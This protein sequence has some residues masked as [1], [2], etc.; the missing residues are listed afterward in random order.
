MKSKK[1]ITL[2]L[3][4]IMCLSFVSCGDKKDVVDDEEQKYSVVNQKPSANQSNK[5]DKENET[6]KKDNSNSTENLNKAPSFQKPSVN[7]SKKGSFVYSEANTELSLNIPSEWE[8]YENPL[9]EFSYII[10]LDGSNMNLITE[11]AYNYSLD[12]Y[13][14]ESLKTL[15]NFSDIN[16]LSRSKVNINGREASIVTYET[17]YQDISFKLYQVNFIVDGYAYIFTFGSPSETYE[18]HKQGFEK[19]VNSIKFHE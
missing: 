8:E 11:Y 19:A 10:S 4:S 16:D 2:T 18:I 5:D 3:L 12:E 6:D 17:S 9:A 1:I 13:D 15:E 7:S 14:N